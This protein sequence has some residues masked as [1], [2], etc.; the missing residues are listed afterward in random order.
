VTNRVADEL[1]DPGEPPEPSSSRTTELR[2]ICDQS[3]ADLVAWRTG[4][5]LALE[6]LV[7][8]LTPMLWHIVRAYR[9]DEATAEDVVQTT[10][11]TLVRKEDTIKDPQTV[12][13]WLTVSARREAARVAEAS[14][15]VDSQDDTTLDLRPNDGPSVEQIVVR[16]HRDQALWEAVNR[17]SERCQK[18]LRIIA[19]GDRPDYGRLADD[20]GMSVGSIGPTRGRCLDKLRGLLGT[21]TDWRI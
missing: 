3:A 6:R 12:V 16:G 14:Q 9:L 19:C 11:L 2:R 7:H 13:R 5:R 8:R 17:L 15:R 10:W 21:A 18:L 4:N 20:L 1:V